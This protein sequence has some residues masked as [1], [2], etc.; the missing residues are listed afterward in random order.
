MIINKNK[1]ANYIIEELKREFSV[2]HLSK[3]LINTVKVLDEG[4]E[5]RIEIPARTYNMLKYQKEGVVVYTSHGSYAS[6]LDK[7]GS[8]FNIYPNSNRTGSFRL[9]TGNH[10]GY[11]DKIINNAL[12]RFL[13]EERLQES[14]REDT[15]E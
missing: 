3:N 10:I 7:E 2:K 13:A 4:D 15:N 1:L 11:V 8:S 6:R 12:Q 5:I 14:K 9:K